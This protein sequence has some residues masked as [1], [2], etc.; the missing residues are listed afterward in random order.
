MFN[1]IKRNLLKTIMLADGGFSLLAGAALTA[2]SAPIAALLGPDFTSQAVLGI[3]LFLVVWGVSHLAAGRTEPL[4]VGA[5]RV[6]I[7]GDALWV[8]ASAALLIADWNGLSA[9]GIAA[10][11]VVAVAVADIMLLKMIGLRARLRRVAA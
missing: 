5:V 9:L 4:P 10:I 3:G 2:F 8:V 6:A 11:A 1:F 7:V